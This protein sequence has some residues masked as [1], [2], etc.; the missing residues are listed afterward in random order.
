MQT[1][2]LHSEIFF[3]CNLKHIENFFECN[4]FIFIDYSST[5][6]TSF[7]CKFIPHFVRQTLPPCPLDVCIANSTVACDKLPDKGRLITAAKIGKTARFSD[8][9]GRR[10]LR[11]QNVAAKNVSVDVPTAHSGGDR[12]KAVSEKLMSP[13]RNDKIRPSRIYCE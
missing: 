7:N 4:Y 9:R 13:R 10:S 6:F 2:F 3:L 11:V 8:R 12:K 5:Y 1:N